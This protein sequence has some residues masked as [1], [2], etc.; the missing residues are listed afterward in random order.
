[1][2]ER[3]HW[4]REAHTSKVAGHFG[5]TKTL[6]NLQRSKP[7]NRKVGLY[8]P[9]PVPSRPWEII[10]MDFL[11][12]LP[13]TRKGNDYLMDT[14]LK[15]S[16]AFHPQT[17]GQT[18]VVNRTVA[19]LLRG[20]SPSEVCLG[21]L[22][23]TSFDFEFTTILCWHLQMKLERLEKHKGLSIISESYIIRLKNNCA[24]HNRSTKNAMIVTELKEIFKKIAYRVAVLDKPI[25]P[26][27]NSFHFYVY[28]Q[29]VSFYF[30][31]CEDFLS[32]V[33]LS[34]LWLVDFCQEPQLCFHQ[35]DMITTTTE[36]PTR[37]LIALETKTPKPVVTLVYLRKPRKS[38]TT[39]LVRKSKVI[40]SVSANKKEPSKSWGS[41]VS[42]I[43]SSSLNEYS[44]PISSTN[45]GVVK[46]RNNHVE[47]IMGYRDYQIRNVTISRVYY[48]EGVGHNLF[49]VGQF[50]DSNLKVAF[51][52]HTCYIR[53][54]EG[55]D[56]LTGSRGN[57]LY[58]LSLGDMMA[59]SLIYLLSKASKTKS[60]LW[61]QCLSYLNFGAINHLARH[62]LVRDLPRLKFEKDHLCSACAMAK[63][64]KKPHKP[65]YEDTNQEKLYLLH[66]DLC[67]PMR[68]TS[69]NGKKY[70]L[71]IVD[72]YSRFTWQNGVTERR[73]RS[74]IEVACTMLTYEK[75]RLFLWAESVAT[76]RTRTSR[77]DSCNNQFKTRAKPSF[78]NTFFTTFKNLLG[79]FALTTFD[80][81]LTPP[82]NFDH[83]AP[84]VIA[85][86]AEVVA[87]EP[88]ASTGSPSSTIVDQDAPSPSNSQTTPKTQTLVISNYVEEDSHDLNVAYMHNNSFFGSSPNMRQMHTPFELVGRWTKDHPIKNAIGDPSCSVSTRKQ[89]QTDA[90]WYFFDDFLTL[91]EPKNFKQAMTEPSWINAMQEE[92]HEF[93]RLENKARL[94]AQGFKQEEGIDFEESFAPVARIEVIRIFI[95]NAAHK[96]MMI[97][98][99]DVKMAF[100]NGELKE[101]VYVSQP[102]GFV[103]QDNPSH[104]YKLRKAFYCIKQA[105]CA[106]YDTLSRFLISQHFSK[107]AVDLTRFTRKA[108]KDI[109]L[110]QV[111][112]EIVELYF[113]RTEYQ[114]ADIFTKPLPRES[115]NFLIKK[116]GIKS[117]SPDTLK[118]PIEEMDE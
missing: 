21:F 65:K 115:F 79:S 37:K 6:Q 100:L 70:I 24:V 85:L 103:D 63:S 58:T 2:V 76:F 25:L 45:L 52:Q 13:K 80:K 3:V 109:L 10:S 69:V 28:Q 29:T 96:N 46:F 53:N 22:P 38:K 50:C 16:T 107:G 104:V 72:D 106:L 84:E 51:C 102:E 30:E 114:L 95:A 12:G 74:L 23:Q 57:N 54:L 71:V 94:V 91:V 42:N 116:L 89:L 43:P 67:G 62:G 111:E 98:Q 41:T 112:N 39:D 26:P 78:F 83:L 88:T 59:S 27:Y 31:L 47:K 117:M 34:L 33:L 11:R 55:V 17:D 113:V 61:H 118:R 92:I 82:P 4:M 44:S 110:E 68:V 75:A 19:H 7:A 99:I 15:R 36:V 73:N 97:L 105:P 32:D 90:M 101:E 93:E 49:F 14:K 35:E 20:K 87:P 77:N 48:V 66:I 81:L 9:L 60:W 40:R 5:V 64:K 56:L 86:I 1:M 108:G 8:T 18:E